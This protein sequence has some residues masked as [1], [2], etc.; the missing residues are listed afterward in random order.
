MAKQLI[1]AT[2]EDYEAATVGGFAPSDGWHI[3]QVHQEPIF[4]EG[5]KSVQFE[6]KVDDSADGDNGKTWRIYP[7]TSGKGVF[8][9]KE[10]DVACGFEPAYEKGKDGKMHLSIDTV[11]YLGQKMR[12]HFRPQTD[13]PSKTEVNQIIAVDAAIPAAGAEVDEAPF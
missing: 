5:G 10:I 1:A 11:R 13:D 12:A 8:K 2:R 9:I 3:V 7:P 6:L 4:K